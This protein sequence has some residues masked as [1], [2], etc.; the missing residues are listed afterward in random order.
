MMIV[1]AILSVLAFIA[2]FQLLQIVPRAKSA[3]DT[4]RSTAAV[5]GDASLSEEAKEAAVQKASLA[6]MKGFVDLLLRGAG[7]LVAAWLPIQLADWAG[8][9]PAADTLGFLLRIDVI[10]VTSVVLVALVV[11]LSKVRK[12]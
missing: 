8:L 1:V 6:L 5:M 7:A 9:V 12:K 3:I 2:A 4:S 10:V 11:I